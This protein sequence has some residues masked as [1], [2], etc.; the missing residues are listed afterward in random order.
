MPTAAVKK[1][2]Q[3]FPKHATVTVSPPQAEGKEHACKVEP[4]V[5]RVRY[6]GT[7]TFR[8]VGGCGP[9]EVF[10]P[11]PSREHDLFP[12]SGRHLAVPGTRAGR[13]FTVLAR[14][15]KAPH[16]VEYPYAVYCRGCNCFG[17]GSLPKMLVGP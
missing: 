1:S 12:R 8:A 4:G 15:H 14:K 3:P 7:V 17:K 13:K 9:L 16:V 6:G 10:V 2:E 11:T 5:V